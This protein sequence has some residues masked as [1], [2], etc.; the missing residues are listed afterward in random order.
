[1]STPPASAPAPGWY[2][3]PAGTNR[4]RWWDGRDWTDFVADDQ[5]PLT[6]GARVNT[7][8][9]WIIA[10][11]PLLP[12]VAMLTWDMQGALRRS[13]ESPRS[14]AFALSADPGYLL[15]QGVGFLMYA[16]IVVLAYVDRR[17]LQRMGVVKPF[18]WAW[19]FLTLVYVIGRAVVLR[20]RVRRGL[21]PLWTFLAVYLVGVLVIGVKVGT[22]VASLAGTLPD[23]GAP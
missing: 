17:A 1:M 14:A 16:A 10:L 13:L 19:S 3:D 9:I 20:R 2:A 7:P 6:E 18:H 11:L 5:P 8:F 4:R 21:A 23:L 15:L 22:V 12:T